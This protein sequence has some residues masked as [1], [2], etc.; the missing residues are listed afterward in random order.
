MAHSLSR[1]RHAKLVAGKKVIVAPT[2]IRDVSWEKARVVVDLTR[3]MIESSP[4]YTP[5]LP[6]NEDYAEQLY[7]HYGRPIESQQQQQKH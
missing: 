1:D 4:P 3:E 7:E 2:W 6:W 5:E